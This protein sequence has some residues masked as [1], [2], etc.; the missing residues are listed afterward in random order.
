MKWPFLSLHIINHDRRFQN[1]VSRWKVVFCAKVLRDNKPIARLSIFKAL[2]TENVHLTRTRVANKMQSES[3]ELGI[4][5]EVLGWGIIHDSLV[6]FWDL[7]ITKRAAAVSCSI[8]LYYEIAAELG[9]RF[10]GPPHLITRFWTSARCLSTSE[11]VAMT[12][13][14]A[15]SCCFSPAI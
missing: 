11:T 10:L 7:L 13:Y 12:G 6:T 15:L 1:K 9:T 2:L 8:A 5:V 4:C 14:A 3:K